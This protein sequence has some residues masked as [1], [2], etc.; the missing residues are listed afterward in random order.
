MKVLYTSPFVPAEWIEAHGLEPCRI[1]PSVSRGSIELPEAG[2]CPFA[3]S[4]AEQ[5]LAASDDA[6]AVFTTRCDQMRRLCDLVGT[7]RRGP[8][9]LL[10]LPA[11]WRN[12]VASRLYAG[13][14]RR[15]GRWLSALGGAAVP[16]TEW[17]R[18][19]MSGDEA[20]PAEEGAGRKPGSQADASAVTLAVTGGPLPGESHFVE[21][22]TQLGGRVVLDATESGAAL[23]A[24]RFDR[25]RLS[26]DP[27]GELARAYLSIPS[28]HQRP[29]YR[30]L[31]WLSGRLAACRAEGLI[32]RR[33]VWCDLW[34]AEAR[35]IANDI[36]VPV[37]DLEIEADS[38]SVQ[39][40]SATRI[41]GFIEMIR[42]ARQ[43][44][45][46]DGRAALT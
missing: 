7:R 28:I 2:V 36:G 19:V 4:F 37:L 27:A 15:F 33:Y 25:E 8:V 26:A 11:T 42:A 45:R 22:V 18:R 32:I 20:Q 46:A 1:V 31:G 41:E 29:N 35:A 24:A 16:R 34:H 10:N 6:A 17:V 14:L 9:F 21:Q 23:R 12:S 44:D 3:R 38:P 43:S 39:T 5:V 30:F 13:E 40:R